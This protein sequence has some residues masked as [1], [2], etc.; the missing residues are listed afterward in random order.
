MSS[1]LLLC[2]LCAATGQAQNAPLPAKDSVAAADA[3]EDAAEAKDQIL[4]VGHRQFGAVATAIP[5]EVVLNSTAIRALGA[6]DLDEVFRDLAPEIGNGASRSPGT[7][8]TPVVLVNGQRIAGFNSIKDFPPEAVRRIEIFP[9]TVALQYGYAPDQR[10]VNVVLRSNYHALTLLGRYTLAPNN[11]R[12]L[13]RAKVDYIRINDDGHWNVGLDYSHQDAL[14]DD[15]TLTGP[16]APTGTQVPRHTLARQDDHLIASGTWNRKIGAI[17]AEVTGK[18]DLDAMQSRPG[19]SDEDG[20]LLDAEGLPNLVTGPY[21]RLD[22][23]VDAQTS[24]TLN[25]K[26]DAWRWSFIG[27]L[28][29][30]TRVTR[31]NTLFA[32]G[33]SQPIMLASP[34]LLGE[35]CGLQVAAGCVS[36]NTRT[37]SGDF[38]LNGD[39]FSLPAGAVTT[40]LRTGFAFSGIRSDS[41]IAP[42]A[43][44]RSEG[45]AQANIEFPLTSRDSTL[46]K[47][48]FGVN[49]EAHQVSDFGMLPTFGATLEW[50]PIK[51]VTLLGSFS[52]TQQAPTLVQLGQAGLAR[53]DL[54]EYDFVT[55][56]T[57]IVQRIEGGNGA[58]D[59]QTAQIG[60]VR[61]QVSPLR[62][63]DLTLSADYTIERTR[64]PIATITAATAATMAAFPDR[65]TRQNGY[66]NGI[67][68]SPVNLARRDRQQ[69]R[70]G[71]TWSTAFGAAWVPRNGGTADPTKPPSRDQFQ[72][73]L[74]DTWRLQDD[75]VL[76][77]GL[78]A[79]DLL[80]SDI[81]SDGGGTPRHQVELQ[82]TVATGPW[83]ADISAVWQTPTKANAGLAG[84]DQLTFTQG[85]ALNMRLQINLADQRWLTRRIPWLRGSL[86]LSADNLLGAHTSVHDA[87]GVVPAAYRSDYVNP[88]GRTFR[89]TLRKHFR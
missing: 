83:S 56:T 17:T 58:L 46:G 23:T 20:A 1:A 55:G 80:G 21:N 64:N 22:Q 31:T 7:A 49:G 71:L 65:F 70:M 72:I 66:L 42:Q 36:T 51:P 68:V 24:L 89:I 3:A 11:W 86:N 18:L 6:A 87:S 52:H 33:D 43:I 48:T 2:F 14:Y 39:L 53:P 78:P 60:R 76:R 54:R 15:T 77:N 81:I 8:G 74:Y 73:A 25:G 57:T 67:D 62:T 16:L 34:T 88:T 63:A 85:I 44:D 35:R 40:A 38:Y 41:L 50:S 45:S 32:H 75:V 29:D 12:G 47:L 59:H 37:A 79:L 69:V 28:D 5:P 61:L 26:L 84:Q 4:V 30:S 27:N 13:Y 82:T 9:S 10:V 19:L